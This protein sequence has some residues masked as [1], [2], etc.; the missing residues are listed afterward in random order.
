MLDLTLSHEE[1]MTRTA[2]FKN[3]ALFNIGCLYIIIPV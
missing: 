2:L 3:V 1:G